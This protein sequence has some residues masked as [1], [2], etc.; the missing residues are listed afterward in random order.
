M[1]EQIASVIWP[2][3]TEP[4][5]SRDEMINRLDSKGREAWQALIEE[6][7][8]ELIERK[9]SSDLVRVYFLQTQKLAFP[10][11]LMTAVCSKIAA[12]FITSLGAV[13]GSGASP[14]VV[15]ANL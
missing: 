11:T 3:L 5:V 9:L 4:L 1:Q 10:P 12:F 2:S 8:G 13:Q 6:P 14:K 15:W 7:L